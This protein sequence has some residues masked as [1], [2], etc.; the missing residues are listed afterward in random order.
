MAKSDKKHLGHTTHAGHKVL[1][2]SHTRLDEKRLAISLAVTGSVFMFILVSLSWLFGLGSALVRILGSLYL[3][4]N[5]SIIGAVFG[6]FYGFLTG[7]LAG[8]L[9]AAI[10]NKAT[11]S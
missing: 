9:F 11:V 10:Y 6:V 8:Y 4:Y 1:L 2:H 3:G 5:V 7:F